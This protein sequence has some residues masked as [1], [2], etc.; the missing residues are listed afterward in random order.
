MGIDASPLWAGRVGKERTLAVK[1]HD[2]ALTHARKLAKEGSVVHDTRDDWSEHAPSTEEQNQFI[3][4][5]GWAAFGDWHLGIDTDS[6]ADT[7][8]RYSFPFGD[9]TKVH[10]CAVISLESRAAQNDH[11][12]ITTATKNLLKLIDA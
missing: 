8:A 10:R 9:F 7:K 11:D 2:S 4:K 1:L 3:E 12:D 5:N 6:P